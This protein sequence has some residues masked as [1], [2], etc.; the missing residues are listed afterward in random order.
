MGSRGPLMFG[1]NEARRASVIGGGSGMRRGTIGTTGSG[2]HAVG[3]VTLAM[4]GVAGMG[5]AGCGQASP[6][7]P[8]LPC[9]IPNIRL[10][11]GDSPM[12]A[13]VGASVLVQ[14]TNSDANGVRLTAGKMIVTSPTAETFPGSPSDWIGTAPFVPGHST[15]SVRFRPPKPG[16]YMVGFVGTYASSCL[17]DEPKGGPVQESVG[18]IEVS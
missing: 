5:L 8:A 14:V 16:T 6:V 9:P 17:A 12:H 15:L 11:N 10:L 13:R 3:G 1:F 18:E 2:R 4:L 7:G